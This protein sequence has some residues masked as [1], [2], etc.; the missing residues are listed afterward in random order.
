MR[1]IIDVMPVQIRS[2]KAKV[3]MQH[4][5]EAWRC[6]KSNYDW[7]VPGMPPL[8]ESIILKYVKMKADWWTK[9]ALLN[10]R[11]IREGFTID[12][13]VC[14]KNVGRLSRLYFKNE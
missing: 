11:K 7:K 5:S 8:I 9:A 14:K 2:N 12:K 13:T 4:L 10:R 3:I 1:E 6:W